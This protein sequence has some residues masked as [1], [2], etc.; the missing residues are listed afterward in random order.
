MSILL[1]SFRIRAFC[2]IFWAKGANA[3]FGP[4]STLDLNQ[5][6]KKFILNRFERER[7]NQKQNSN[8]K[9]KGRGKKKENLGGVRGEGEREW[10]W[11]RNS[12]TK[13]HTK[14]NQLK[15]AQTKVSFFHI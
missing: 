14:Q 6:V 4:N 13:K 9:L 10:C 1:D 11:N 15:H 12:L 5:K 2:Y 3:H 7:F 8:T